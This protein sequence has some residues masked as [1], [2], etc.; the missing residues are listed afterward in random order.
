VI[1]DFFNTPKRIIKLKN[2]DSDFQIIPETK[3]GALI[4][5]FPQLEKTLIEIS[6]KFKQLRN[7]VL[8]RT[9]AR[10]ASLS[11]VAAIGKASLVDMINKLREEAGITEKFISD[12]DVDI[13]PTEK[14]DWF[15]SS[16]IAVTL[17]ARPMLE[18]GKQPVQRVL[19]ECKNLKDGEIYELIT[20]FL[21]APLIDAA[22]KQEYLTWSRKEEEDV[23]KTYFMKN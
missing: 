11:Q 16:R 17:D 19:N 8:R 22:R 6:P 4:D 21:P 20:P 9:I 10:V 23:F 12:I 2:S 3:V 5:R 18:E 14:P 15:S 13:I 1:R 7:P